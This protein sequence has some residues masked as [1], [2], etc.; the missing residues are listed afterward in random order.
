[1][2]EALADN[3]ETNAALGRGVDSAS[4]MAHRVVDTM[5]GLANQAADGL[6]DK[7]GELRDAHAR[8]SESCRV[9]VRERPL[10]V[11][12]IAVAASFALGWLLRP[13]S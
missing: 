7:G 11:L 4:A 2:S 8:L 5:A 10:T 12:G 3:I 1:M 13:R 6:G 9:Q